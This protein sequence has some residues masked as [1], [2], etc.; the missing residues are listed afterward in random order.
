[1][2]INVIHLNTLLRLFYM[3]EN[4]LISELR[5]DIRAEN[6][7][8]AGEATSGGGH[9]YMPFW[10]DVKSHVLGLS[11]LKDSTSARIAKDPGKKDLYEKLEQGFSTLWDRGGNQKVEL[12]DK[13]PKGAYIIKEQDLTIKVENIMAITLNGN[14]RLGYPYWFPHPVL[15]QEGACVGLY[16]MSKAL[17]TQEKDNFRIF[18]IIRAD[19]FSLDNTPLQGNEEKIILENFKR[20]S[21]LREKLKK[22]Y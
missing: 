14:E 8:E 5:K 16:V 19:F 2:T 1:M 12:I 17:E 6:K 18:D 4:K 3:P 7:K 11:D 22:E 13:S 20:I 9:F 21:K 10:S 15:S